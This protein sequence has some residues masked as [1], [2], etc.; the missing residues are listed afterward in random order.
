MCRQVHIS[1]RFTELY[2]FFRSIDTTIYESFPSIGSI[3]YMGNMI[4][5]HFD[6]FHPN[7][8]YDLFDFYNSFWTP[9][10]IMFY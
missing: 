2:H 9:D 6:R 5:I 4:E 1:N 8:I 3:V 10:F 7:F